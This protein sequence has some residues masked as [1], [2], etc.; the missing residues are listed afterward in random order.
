MT[1]ET[2][3]RIEQLRAEIRRHDY[4][5]YVL[6]QP[7]ISD[8]QYDKLFTELKSLEEQHPELITPDSPTQRV[9]KDLTRKTIRTE[10]KS[11]MAGW[12]A[13]E[14]PG[15]AGSSGRRPEEAHPLRWPHVSGAADPSPNNNPDRGRPYAGA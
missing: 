1:T 5:Y 13:P 14:N 11:H 12:K 15:F 8:Q 3:K 9:G 7:Q 6:N 10:K 2:R 4:L